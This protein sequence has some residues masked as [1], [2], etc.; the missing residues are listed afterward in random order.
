MPYEWNPAAYS[1][2][3]PFQKAM[4]DELVGKLNLKDN[5]RV[6]DLG[7]GDGRVTAELA[8]LVPRG[9]V[10][11]ID[12]SPVMIDYARHA[13]TEPDFPNLDFQVIDARELAF[14]ADF[15]IVF[16]NAV[17]H[18]VADH[19]PVLAGL[20]RALAPGGRVLLQMGGKDNTAAMVATT[21]RLT[22]SKPWRE[23]FI[24]FEFPW[25]FYDAE[26]YRGWVEEA[27]LVADRVELLV[28]DSEYDSAAKFAGWFG[29][30]WLPYLERVPA[31]LR[32]EFT[33][34]AVREY[35]TDYPPDT[36]GRVALRMMR[37][38]VAAHKA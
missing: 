13:Y 7:C 17:L 4:A 2:N 5:D 3:S 23:Y 27:G 38:E 37:L 34:A 30:T 33:R 18:W 22:E 31:T 20:C 8:R 15:D 10:T 36:E 26:E 32:D 19:R 25:Y 24:D 35:L 21:R 28:R 6:L 11:G 16:S 29:T 12:L 1:A 14:D 9:R